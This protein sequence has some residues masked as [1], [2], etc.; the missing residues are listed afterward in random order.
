MNELLARFPAEDSA[1]ATRVVEAIR[2]VLP[3]TVSMQVIAIRGPLVDLAINDQRVTAR[4]IGEGWLPSVQRALALDAP[5]PD[6]VVARKI[7]RAS[8][9]KLAESGVGWVDETGAAEVVS[10][11]LILSRTGTPDA[12]KRPRWTRSTLAVSE[13]VL[14]GS[15]ATVISMVEAT[16]LST[17]TCAKALRTLTELGLLDSDAPRGRG[18]ARYVTDQDAL[19][20]AYVGAT[21]SLASPVSLQVGIT[22]QDPITRLASAG[23]DWNRQGVEWVATGPAA[24]AV[25]APLLTS[26]GSVKVYVNAD[27]VPKLHALA[28]QLD[29]QPI[30][31][32]RLTLA[33]F[34]TTTSR[35]LATTVGGLRVAPW[36]RVFADLQ[37][38]GVRGEEAAAHLREV[39]G[40]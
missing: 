3:T 35:T 28:H 8:Q 22:W 9:A 36:P 12:K 33:P 17:G 24:A 38:S 18:S 34:P 19:L 26:I 1:V 5:V 40:A 15:P 27:T 37:T 32:G 14:S 11:S 10:G 21:E 20:A 23:E 39:V 4:W 25:M 29:L 16:G 31:G 30:E 2:A 6:L 13:A 7:P